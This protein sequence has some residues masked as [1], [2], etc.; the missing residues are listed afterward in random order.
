MWKLRVRKLTVN[1]LVNFFLLS[2]FFAETVTG[3]TAVE[4]DLT[5][6]ERKSALTKSR[7]IP[8]VIKKMPE[9]PLQVK[10]VENKTVNYGNEL[11]AHKLEFE[12]YRVK[13]PCELQTYY[14]LIMIDPDV[15]SAKNPKKKE[16][17]LW[18]VGNIRGIFILTAKHVAKY[19]Q[20]DP[21]EDTG[22]HRIVFI[23]FKQPN[24]VIK[25]NETND[26]ND[27]GDLDCRY[28]FST[29]KFAK[30]YNLGDPY[31]VN[32]FTTRWIFVPTTEDL[33]GPEIPI[34]DQEQVVNWDDD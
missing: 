1:M 31:A 5:Y 34:V 30:K 11:E 28:H 18:L 8:E 33:W 14:T 24:G 26:Y 27:L 10:Y 20:P 16:E 23:L 17:L 15:P 9:H 25:F 21:E 29:K 22:L 12:P 4:C 13:W 7:I 6:E 19:L 2:P 32:F 3:L